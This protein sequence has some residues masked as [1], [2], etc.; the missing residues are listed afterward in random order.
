MKRGIL[1]IL[2]IATAGLFMQSCVS[3]PNSPGLEYMPDMYRSHAVEAYVDYGMDPYHFGDSLAMAQNSTISARQPVAGTIQ[4]NAEFMPYVLKNTPDDYEK[5]ATEVTSPIAMTK[6]HIEK[7]K[8]IYTRMCSHCHGDKGDG[9][10]KLVTNEKILGVP[11]FAVQLKDLP[12]GKMFHT[13]THGK[14]IMGSHAAQVN[15]LERWQIIQYIHILQDGGTMPKFDENGYPEGYEQHWSANAGFNGE[16]AYMGKGNTGSNDYDFGA[17]YGEYMTEMEI[18]DGATLGRPGE[19]QING[20][21]YTIEETQEP[22]FWD[23]VKGLWAKVKDA[24]TKD[25]H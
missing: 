19:V 25:K 9:Q 5:S 22:G 2:T 10:G 24:L 11:N 8:E 18:I 20:E 12:E 4:Y 3:D 7:G 13:I 6:D 16:G 23:K 15:Q 21:W 17:M 1:F 14:G